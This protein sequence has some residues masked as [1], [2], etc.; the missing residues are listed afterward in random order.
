MATKRLTFN[1]GLR[2]DVQL[3]YLERYNRMASQFNIN[4]VNPLSSQILNVWN[5]DAAA[6]NATNPK[7]P[8]P[9]AP[10]AL[11]GVWQFAG[12]NGLPRRAQYTDWTN[13]APRIGFAFRATDKTVIRG[14]FG[15]FYQSITRDRKST[16]LNSSHLGISY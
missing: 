4:T 14:G 10:P 8:Y 9:A 6:Y 16:R 1:I 12:Q 2:Y 15:V 11:Y 7:Y 3:P 13:G 5:Q